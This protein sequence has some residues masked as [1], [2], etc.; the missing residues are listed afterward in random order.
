MTNV[1]KAKYANDIF[2]T[3]GEAYARSLDMGFDGVTHVS[4]YDGQ[5]VYMPAESQEAYLAYYAPQMIDTPHEGPEN[6]SEDRMEVMEYALAAVVEAIMEFVVNK[7]A[8][9]GFPG[10]KRIPA[11]IHRSG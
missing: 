3:E 4:T 2:T 1:L 8:E 6:G 10:S 9:D 5:A 11:Q 7:Q